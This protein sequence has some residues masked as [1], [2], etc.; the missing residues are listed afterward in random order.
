MRLLAIGKG[1]GEFGKELFPDFTID[2]TSLKPSK[3]QVG[4]DAILAF[5]VLNRVSYRDYGKTIGNWLDALK[6]DGELHLFVPSL[7]WAAEQVLSEEPSP[8]LMRHLFGAQ[9]AE[10]EFSIS[11]MTLRTA[12]DILANAGVAVTHAAAG[13]YALTFDGKEYQADH[14]YILGKK[15]RN[16]G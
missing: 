8:L 16:A 3:K 9:T 12:R 13:T 10:D 5:H 1:A 4:Y 2:T 14:M 7:E 15:K 6:P 11:G